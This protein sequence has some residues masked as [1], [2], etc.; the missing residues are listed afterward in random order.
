MSMTAPTVCF[1]SR[2]DF[3]SKPG[4]D[5]VQWH[6]YDRTARAAGLRTVK[7]FADGPRPE[8]DV[9]HAFNIDR[10]LELYPRLREVKK[11][12][13]PFVLST[14]HH[15]NAWLERFRTQHPP[16]GRLG[17]LLYR[18]PLGKSVPASEAV[19]EAVRLVQQRRL[20]RFGDLIPGWSQRVAWLLREADCIT[21]L[22]AKEAEF[23]AEDFSYTCPPAQTAIIPNWVEGVGT[24]DAPVP[25]VFRELPEAPVIVIGRIEARKNVLRLARLAD[26]AQ[27][28]V[29][30]VGRPNPNEAGYA[31]AM[32]AAVAASRFA[33]WI[34]GVPREEMAGFYAHASFLLNASY[35][36]VSPLVDIEALM[37]GCPVTTTRFAL[38]HALLPAETPVCDAYDDAD[39]VAR[40]AWRPVR[41]TPVNVI[42]PAAVQRDL[43]DL[44]RRLAGARA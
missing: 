25:A 36:E 1:I 28:P 24:A 42:D 6:M 29:L 26:R 30:F 11:A 23:L 17:R 22:S 33:K 39:L 34:P 27:R 37:F 10:P 13:R 32:Q 20:G 21:L 2:L 38:H 14:I 7:W 44:Y 3:E 43:L 35:V 12:G 19:K 4:G 41:R 9:Y 31:E 18:S 16:S 8:A 5:T 15:P 40:L